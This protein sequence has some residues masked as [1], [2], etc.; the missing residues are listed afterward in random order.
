[1]EILNLK[2]IENYE[3]KM[4]NFLQKADN[5]FSNPLHNRINL[6]DYNKKIIEFADIFVCYDK[7][8]IVGSF[9]IYTNDNILK[10]SNA[11]LL[12]VLGN[13][14][15]KGI[16]EK[17][18]KIGL[19]FAKNKK[20]K[21]MKLDTDNKIALKMYLNLKFKIISQEGNRYYLEKNLEEDQNE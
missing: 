21:K 9:V 19:V 6:K 5:L 18:F 15:G 8:E 1:M 10:I 11:V 16:G 13:Y 4:L 17:L 7:E 12:V 2:E 20:M 3:E 14:Q